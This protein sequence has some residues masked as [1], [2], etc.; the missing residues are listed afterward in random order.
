[1]SLK[2]DALEEMNQKLTSICSHTRY[3]ERRLERI[4]GNPSDLARHMK[5]DR[6]KR[7]ELAAGHA[8]RKLEESSIAC[9]GCFPCWAACWTLTFHRSWRRS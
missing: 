6:T 7:G 1:M 4:E 3:S 8:R 2:L 9:L 5:N